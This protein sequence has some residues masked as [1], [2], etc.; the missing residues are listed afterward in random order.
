MYHYV[1]PIIDSKYPNIKGLELTDFKN[2][3]QFLKKN[4]KKIIGL[5]EFQDIKSKGNLGDEYVLLTFDDGYADIYKHVFP[6]L[7]KEKMSGVFFVPTGII[8]S[9]TLLDV[10]L[11]HYLLSKSDDLV[12]EY[13]RFIKEWINRNRETYQLESYQ[14]YV[15]KIDKSTNKFDSNEVIIFKRLLQNE[16]P[17]QIRSILIDELLEKYMMI[18]KKLLHDE[19]YVNVD[20]LNCM[21]RN[22]MTIG[23]HSKTH[24]WLNYL[25]E[26]EQIN[27]IKESKIFLQNLEKQKYLSFAYPYGGYNQTTIKILR[28]MDIKFSFTTSKGSYDS[29]NNDDLE[30][31]RYDTNDFPKK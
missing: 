16:F 25:N 26:G 22:G 6:I 24:R 18:D 29:S 8:N 13:N 15:D 9:T 17:Q 4:K 27:E 1:R 14:D 21:I 3:L 30:I 5:D 20:Q 28:K 23:G 12:I 31:P 2:Q 10:N 7:D 19:W 11:I